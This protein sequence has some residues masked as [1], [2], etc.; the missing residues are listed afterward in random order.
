[1]ATQV[2]SGGKCIFTSVDC[3]I[4]GFGNGTLQ[5]CDKTCGLKA[6]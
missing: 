6:R 3:M 2:Y 5:L 4:E 1:M